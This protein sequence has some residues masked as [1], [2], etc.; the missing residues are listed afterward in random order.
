MT[1]YVKSIRNQS[2]RTRSSPAPH[3]N[4]TGL[5]ASC[6]NRQTRYSRWISRSVD[7]G[8]C[9]SGDGG[10]TNKE[11]F[12]S[13]RDRRQQR[14]TE[15]EETPL[16]TKQEVRRAGKV[17]WGR[18]GR[19]G[20]DQRTGGST[21]FILSFSQS[22]WY[23]YERIEEHLVKEWDIWRFEGS[24][25]QR[26]DSNKTDKFQTNAHSSWRDLFKPEQL[27]LQLVFISIILI[28]L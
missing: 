7:S 10:E 4:S 16:R 12:L 8:P 19:C 5:C 1:V 9:V 25:V 23:Q 18:R 2:T 22:V 21:A 14:R 17:C 15:T 6:P 26:N 13:D 28:Q 24:D 3:V 20:A 11:D 27:G